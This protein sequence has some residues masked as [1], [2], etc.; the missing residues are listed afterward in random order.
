MGSRRKFHDGHAIDNCV[1]AIGKMIQ[2]TPDQLAG[3]EVIVLEWLRMMPMTHD[4]LEGRINYD[5]LCQLLESHSASHQF[6]LMSPENLAQVVR[7]LVAA[8]SKNEDMA[9][10]IRGLLTEFQATLAPALLQHA[11]ALLDQV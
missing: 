1:S 10:R 9:G 11:W 8:A 5:I 4:E 6:L 3:Y 2:F 7:V